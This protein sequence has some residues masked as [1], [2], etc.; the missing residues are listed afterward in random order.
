MIIKRTGPPK[1]ALKLT[2]YR[3]KTTIALLLQYLR[4]F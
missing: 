4:D 3:T 2:N 1:E